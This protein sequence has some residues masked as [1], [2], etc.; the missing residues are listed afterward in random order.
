MRMTTTTRLVLAAL[1]KD[2]NTERYGYELAD[3]TG[4]APGTIYPILLRLEDA[5]WVQ[6]RWEDVDPGAEKR[7]PRRYFLLTT[8]GRARAELILE[9]RSRT[10]KGPAGVRSSHAGGWSG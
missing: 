6:A 9:R 5:G 8:A 1:L 10:G 2:P 4:L 3:A 7:P